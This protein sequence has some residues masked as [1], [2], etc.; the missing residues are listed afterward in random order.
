MPSPIGFTIEGVEKIKDAIDHASRQPDNTLPTHHRTSSSDDRW[1]KIT[2]TDGFSGKY[3]WVS[4]E[5]TAA[6]DMTANSQWLSANFDDETN[7]A[8]EINGNK[9]VIIDDIVY[10]TPAKSQNYFLFEYDRHISATTDGTMSGRVGTAAGVGLVV[11]NK[12]DGDTG[13]YTVTSQSFPCYNTYKG[14]VESGKTIQIH[15]TY[16]VWETTGD[17]CIESDGT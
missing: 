9:D 3:S 15:T 17:D 12:L 4:L 8:V 14:T 6:Q 2:D 11:P 16:G 13:Q 7:Y 1:V 10:L 5:A